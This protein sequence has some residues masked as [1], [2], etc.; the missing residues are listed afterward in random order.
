MDAIGVWRG[1]RLA[2]GLVF[3]LGG[4]CGSSA[5]SGPPDAAARDADAPSDA[6]AQDDAGPQDDASTASITVSGA[7]NVLTL[8]SCRVTPAEIPDVPAG[9]PYTITLA[10]STLSKGVVASG[11]ASVDN[12]VL[13]HLP[14]PAT[15]PQHDRTFFMLNGVGATA[16]FTLAAPG[17]VQ[18]MFIDSDKASNSGTA[19]V[20]LSPGGY[21][22]TVDAAANV[23]RWQEG[24]SSTPATTEHDGR[25]YELRLVESSLPYA[26]VI[27]RL[28]SETPDDDHRYV[29]LNGVG[30]TWQSEVLTGGTVRAWFVDATGAGA[31]E[32]LIAL[33]PR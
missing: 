1:A 22:T 7:A 21:S 8:A 9:G 20:T 11:A 14:L 32:A 23:L 25:A 17:T 12:Y 5:G 30:A 6:P 2:L 29:S 15:D 10:A 18:A 16:S 3:L 19:T 27:L 31:G 28:P 33:S 24:C 13:I 4:G 26:A